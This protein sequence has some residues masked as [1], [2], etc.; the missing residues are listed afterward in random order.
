MDSIISGLRD[1]VLVGER[2]GVRTNS[3]QGYPSPPGRSPVRASLTPFGRA[4]SGIAIRDVSRH[5]LPCKPYQSALPGR[6]RRRSSLYGCHICRASFSLTVLRP[7]PGIAGRCPSFQ[8]SRP[9]F[10]EGTFT[11]M[12]NRCAGPWCEGSFSRSPRSNSRPTIRDTT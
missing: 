10:Y 11:P 1:G 3:L 2:K 6:R 9:V 12:P 8:R 5:F 4:I 7:D